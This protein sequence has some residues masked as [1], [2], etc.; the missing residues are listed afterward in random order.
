MITKFENVKDILFY[1][2]NI[3]TVPSGKENNEA[4]A[5][6]AIKNL[7]D[8]GFVIDKAGVEAL[9]TASKEDI[10]NWY[11]ETSEKLKTLVGAD[12][13]YKPF[14]PNFPNDVMNATEIELLMNQLT[15]YFSAL[16]T[17]VIGEEV[18]WSP[19]G[20]NE[21]KGQKPLEEHPLKVIPT[22]DVGD[23][24]IK[25]L[26]ET[27]V[28]EIFKNTLSS[29]FTPSKQ[30]MENIVN[31]YMQANPEWT[32]EASVVE[33][34]QMLAYLYTKAI[35]SNLDTSNMPSLVTNDYLK[36]AQT[37]SFMKENQ[38]NTLNDLKSLSVDE[39]G[40]QQKVTS[41]PNSMRKFI[42]RGLN[43]QKNLEEDV[44]RNKPQWKAVFRLIH[45]GSMKELTHVNEVAQK[46]RNN[47]P[48]NTFY[49]KIEKA[50]GE[51]RY[52]DALRMYA[53][54][55]G[56]F[57]KNLNRL[58]SVKVEDVEQA[59]EYTSELIEK[60]K[61]VFAKTRPEDLVNIV[62]YLNARARDDMLAVHNVKGKMFVANK[63][64]EPIPQK[65]VDLFNSIAKDAIAEQIKTG[66]SYG[67]VYLDPQME[68]MALPKPNASETASL[69]SYTQGSRIPIEKDENGEPKKMRAL[70]WFGN[71]N[72]GSRWSNIVDISAGFFRN[73]DGKLE[74]L[75]RADLSW[76][77]NN[78][79]MGCYFSGDWIGAGKEGATEYIDLDFKS[80]KDNNVD[81][82]MMYVNIYSGSNEV[83]TFA[84]EDVVFGWQER[85][86]LRNGDQ[87]DPKAVQQYC[88]LDGNAAGI[89]PIVIDVKNAEI[90]WTEALDFNARHSS[91]MRNNIKNMEAIVDKYAKGDRMSMADMV[92]IAV[93]ANGGEFVN[94]P[95]EA[96]TLFT[97]KPYDGET[98]Q[99]EDAEKKVTQI[100][101]TDKDIWLGQFMTPQ[102]LEKEVEIEKEQPQKKEPTTIAD[103]IAEQF[104]TEHDN[105]GEQLGI[106]QETSDGEMENEKIVKEEE[107]YSID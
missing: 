88:K 48:L 84:K 45:I 98:K 57:V 106:N 46:I 42:A 67:K 39:N 71:P 25:G 14:Y 23:E 44:A 47:Q 3:L 95:S 55:P 34:R 56:E 29:K 19:E 12:K 6:T 43:E 69:N 91:S 70:L 87:M 103:M 102:K 83:N 86:D 1:A 77:G 32:K 58:I 31:K 59:K 96:D 41:L 28:T 81:Y 49:S 16:V 15:H 9:K 80:L 5:M 78:K 50:F 74:H 100:T 38:T 4:L 85:A 99:Y 27:E 51:H 75:D 82:V 52:Q 63:Q 20:E 54:R 2:R 60:T 35:M 26:A 89:T 7:S 30:D 66:V 94:E 64:Y 65:T 18:T 79:S 68:K 10:T 73:N 53:S 62:S 105:I 13:E 61:E 8:Y 93:K 37:Y 36:I 90:V 11:Y 92:R 22:F 40:K 97:F 101:A 24:F 17:D 33:N 104:A 21:R 72:G 107:E 76:Y